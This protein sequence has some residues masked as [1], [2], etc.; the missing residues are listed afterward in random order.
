MNKQTWDDGE[1]LLHKVY[2]E[3]FVKGKINITA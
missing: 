3:S 2:F 1:Q